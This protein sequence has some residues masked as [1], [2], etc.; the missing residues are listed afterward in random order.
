MCRYQKD[1]NSR[2]CTVPWKAA[3][4]KKKATLADNQGGNQRGAYPCRMSMRA[5]QGQ[6]AVNI[7]SNI[8]E[9]CMSQYLFSS[10][11]AF[12]DS[13]AT[14][15][16]TQ[17]SAPLL[18]KKTL[19]NAQPIYL[20]NGDTIKVNQSGVLPN[21]PMLDTTTKTAQICQH[22]NNFSLISLGKL[23]DGG[24]EAK[25]NSKMCTV[26]KDERPIIKAP[27]YK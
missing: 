17:P 13:A 7:V 8:N 12:I 10:K 14:D 22:I 21:L 11:T 27:R 9:T 18:N 1:H 25:L 19:H 6:D 16:Y 5:W 23:C 24:C 26:Y 20:T 3:N 15:H 2:D 4:H